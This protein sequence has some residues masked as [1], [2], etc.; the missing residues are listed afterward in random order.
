MKDKIL[1]MPLGDRMKYYEKQY[2]LEIS[3]D[4]HLCIRIDGHKFSS[5]THG[6]KKPF[7]D[8]L[9]KAMELTAMDLL[10]E[11]NAVTSYVQSDEISLIIPTYKDNTV[12][13]RKSTK[14]KLHKCVKED[15]K[16]NYSGRVQKIASLIAGFTTMSFNK[17]LKKLTNAYYVTPDAEYDYVMNIINKK[18]GNA[19]F[20]ARVYGVDSDEEAFNSI[21]WRSR[22][23]TKNSKSGFA[24]AYCSHKQLQNLSSQEQIDFCFETTGKDWNTIEDRYKYGLIIKKEKYIKKVE[25]N[26]FSER[27]EVS[28]VIRTRVVSISKPLDKFSKENVDFVMSKVMD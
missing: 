13:N 15:W 27:S 23:N 5:F 22:D 24:Q 21:M 4:S 11:F 26:A 9:S 6:F 7:D 17:H 8:I 20:D 10:T 1:D 28:E 25:P 3:S 2:E 12:D 18:L 14:H 19:W 16:H